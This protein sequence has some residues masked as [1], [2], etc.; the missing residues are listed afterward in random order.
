MKRRNRSGD[1]A[2]L[3]ARRRLTVEP[4]EG[5]R[6]LSVSFSQPAALH[7]GTAAGADA[8]DWQPQI[9]TDGAGNWVAAWCS[10][11]SLGGVIGIDWDIL[12]SRSTDNG[13]TWSSPA[14]L[15]A[16][17]ATDIGG[18]WAPQ[19]ATDGAGNWVAVWYSTDTLG[20][21]IGPDYD[22]LVA[23]S[24][25]NGRSWSMAGPL[26]TNAST[27]AGNDYYP[28]LA[29]DRAGHWVAV[30][31]SDDPL[32]NLGTDRDILIS[33]S[34]DNGL[35]WTAPEALNNN[36]HVDSSDDA[37][38]RVTSDGAGNWVAVW[39][40][41][42]FAGSADHEVLVARST[43]AG[44]TWSF[45]A[46]LNADAATD[47]REDLY[48]QV[49]TDG[50]GHWVAAWHAWGTAGSPTGNDADLFFAR[51]TDDGRTW[52][53][54]D[55]L[56]RNA[57]SDYGG[58]YYARV[59]ADGRGNWIA[60]WESDDSLGGTIGTD[61]DVLV[62]RS[63]DN[64]WSWS[65]PA[66]LNRNAAGDF[67]ADYGP[68]TATDGKGNWVA[69]WE[70]TDSLG[71]TIGTDSDILVARTFLG[72]FGDAPAS[73][74]TLLQDD[75]A[76][77]SPHP[78]FYLGSLVD[79][80]SDGRATHDATGDD[81]AYLADEDGVAF[82]TPWI[83]GRG[84]T[85]TVTASREGRLDAWIDVDGDGVFD[86]LAEQFFYSA[87][88]AA[89][90][91]PLWLVVPYD[92]ALGTTFVRF[93]FSSAGGLGPTGLAPDGEVEDYGV[94]IRSALDTVA[95]YAPGAGVFYLRNS[96]NPGAADA[97]FGYGPA[98]LG[99]EPL[100]GDW[101]GD[102]VD[103]VGVYNPTTGTFYLRNSNTPGAADLAFVY[104]PGG[105]GWRPLV[106]DWDAD[107][108]DTVGVYNPLAGTFYL[109]H[110]NT[111][112]MADAAFNFGPG[113]LGW[114]PLVGDWDGN[115]FVSVGVYDPAASTFHLRNHLM[116][117]PADRA[118]GYGPAASGWRPLA[119]D[120]DGAGGDTVGLYD[121]A[122]ATFYLT[123]GNAPGAADL[124]FR[125]G[126]GGLGWT[127]LAG[128]WN[129]PAAALTA[130]AGE[131]PGNGCLPSL[132]QASLAPIVRE[133]IADWAA[134]GLAAEQLE[135]FASIRFVITDLSGPQLGLADRDVIYLDLDAAGRGWFADPTP[136]DDA[137]FARIDGRLHAV[138]AEAVDRIDLLTVVLHELG[139]ALGLDDRAAGTDG[140]MG[141]TLPVGLRREPGTA[142]IDAVFAR[143]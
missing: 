4:L 35:T 84:A 51:S 94:P 114:L 67:G 107:G 82:L 18:D 9:A 130:A 90:P 13:R 37:A 132:T 60:V 12:V 30:W 76:R 28:Q 87:P 75:G 98:G 119:H 23:R 105:L 112:G 43:N 40:A 86:P 2:P 5:R 142:E 38:P 134:L 113:G 137:E 25:D 135:R 64:G 59:T 46:A 69:V 7:A 17:A 133:A 26:N 123:N 127:P 125:Y 111:P 41:Q 34:I 32:G 27:D 3:S 129:G 66:P 131:I 58:D 138:D 56:N 11:D 42:S 57:T 136:G 117:G 52:T 71:G 24:T 39:S 122:T 53:T 10:E 61:R 22:V 36:A 81:T 68:Q 101:N 77:H 118:F 50:A 100:V 102:G 116:A 78:S 143:L 21:T 55:M 15:N 126:A 14:P 88:L 44:A 19:L 73:Y 140:L 108:I 45:P 115:G 79:A 96:N 70:S 49:T 31:Y 8:D 62:S 20:G 85:L 1:C 92:T 65:M 110:S 83:R 121:P 47:A 6:L 109:R 54:P 63:I 103:T 124:T 29:T 97:A 120:W 48:P 139:H 80:E 106:G 89:G 99:W 16:N 93:R 74:G 72:D 128:D 91:N 141:G 95:A 104:G 33:R